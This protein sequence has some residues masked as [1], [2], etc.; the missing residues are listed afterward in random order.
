MMMVLSKNR[1]K[2]WVKDQTKGV[3]VFLSAFKMLFYPHLHHGGKVSLKQRAQPHHEIVQSAA[4]ST[5]LSPMKCVGLVD[6]GLTLI[7]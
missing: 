4:H 5:Q 2:N 6:A 3:S 1:F 7:S